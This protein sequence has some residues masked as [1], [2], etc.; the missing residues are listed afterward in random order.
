MST[1]PANN[2]WSGTVSVS[3]DDNGCEELGP[4]SYLTNTETTCLASFECAF[5]TGAAGVVAYKA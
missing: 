1:D 5:G 4:F 2:P 3:C